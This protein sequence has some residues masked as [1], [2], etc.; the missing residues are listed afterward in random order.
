MAQALLEITSSKGKLIVMEDVELGH[1]FAVIPYE[2]RANPTLIRELREQTLDPWRYVNGVGFVL[3]LTVWKQQ[4]SIDIDYVKNKIEKYRE[5]LDTV[6]QF[7]ETASAKEP[8]KKTTKKKKS[9]KK[10]KKKKS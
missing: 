3:D 7:L 10:S 6:F 5:I 1:V 8:K 2:K 9:K 4:S